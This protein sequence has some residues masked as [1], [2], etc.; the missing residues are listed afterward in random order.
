MRSIPKQ[1]QEISPECLCG[2]FPF[3]RYGAG[4]SGAS[5]ENDLIASSQVKPT[6]HHLSVTPPRRFPSEIFQDLNRKEIQSVLE[7]LHYSVAATTGDDVFHVLQLLKEAVACPNVIGGVAQLTPKGAFKDFN[8]VINISYSSNWLYTYGKNGYAEVDPVLQSA[9]SSFQTQIWEQTYECA[10]SPK[11]LAFIEEAR[12]FGLTHGITTGMVEPTKNFAT[13]FS[14]AGGDRRGAIRY[15]DLLQYLLPYLH[16]VL[17]ANTETPLSNRVKG[18]SPREA[19]VLVWMKQGKTNWEISKIL[20]ISE[21]T[22]RF[23]VESIFSKLD[24]SSRTQAVAY[25]MEHG[26]VKEE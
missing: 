3:I 7:I 16:R 2:E 4:E 18:L 24:V 11:Q 10:R 9:V 1:H 19:A 14:F 22:I 13:F 15:K 23:H 12:S 26:L 25:A 21:R 6:S 20:G 8:S 5:P 17:I